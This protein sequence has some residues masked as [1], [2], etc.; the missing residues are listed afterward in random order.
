[1]RNLTLKPMHSLSHLHATAIRTSIQ[2]VYF[3]TWGDEGTERGDYRH[4]LRLD[5][6]RR[7]VA[8]IKQYRENG[9]TEK[10]WQ[11]IQY[12]EQKQW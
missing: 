8:V 11:H 1:M 10:L 2:I 6:E 7:E 3:L 12:G 5:E 9:D 4:E